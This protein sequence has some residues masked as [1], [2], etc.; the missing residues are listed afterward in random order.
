MLFFLF[1]GF[2][3]LFFF[4][5]QQEAETAKQILMMTF[6]QN[7]FSINYETLG[8]LPFQSCQVF[9]WKIAGLFCF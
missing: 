2:F 7:R 1:V 5:L 6:I 9:V 3:F 8:S 4:N